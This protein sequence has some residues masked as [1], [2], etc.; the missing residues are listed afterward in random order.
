MKRWKYEG[1]LAESF[2]PIFSQLLETKNFG[3]D[4]RKHLPNIKFNGINHQRSSA[5]QMFKLTD[6][7]F[8]ICK[9]NIFVILSVFNSKVLNSRIVL[10]AVLS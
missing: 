8:L 1:K 3:C 4:V 2:L 5:P 6:Q 7:N 9:F 10:T